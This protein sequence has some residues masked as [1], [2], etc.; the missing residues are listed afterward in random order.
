MSDTFKFSNAA[1]QINA[2]ERYLLS[3]QSTTAYILQ[4]I[5]PFNQ[6]NLRFVNKQPWRSWQDDDD[7]TLQDGTSTDETT[8]ETER[9]WFTYRWRDG[10]ACYNVASLVTNDW[11]GCFFFL[12]QIWRSQFLMTKNQVALICNDD[13]WKVVTLLLFKKYLLTKLSTSFFASCVEQ[14]DVERTFLAFSE[15]FELE[16]AFFSVLKTSE[17]YY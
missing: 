14:F 8:T 7:R 11:H 5:W 6:C 2:H 4:R 13:G 1:R 9:G 3:S 12:F 15:Q 16:R 17:A 10:Q